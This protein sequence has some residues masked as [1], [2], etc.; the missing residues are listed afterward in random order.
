[1]QHLTDQALKANLPRVQNEGW[2]PKLANSCVIYQLDEGNFA[3]VHYVVEEGDSSYNDPPVAFDIIHHL[4]PDNNR[5]TAS[6]TQLTNQQLA[7]SFQPVEGG[8]CLRL[9]LLPLAS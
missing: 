8:C 7:T 6:S 2:H 9:A 1:M 5:I 4:T 3:V